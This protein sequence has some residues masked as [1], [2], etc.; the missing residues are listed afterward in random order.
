MKVRITTT[1]GTVDRSYAEGEEIELD[2]ADAKQ[3]IEAGYAEPV[4][5]TKAK[6]AS[7]RKA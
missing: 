4:G 3:L 6:R 2:K 7:T 1:V 5:T